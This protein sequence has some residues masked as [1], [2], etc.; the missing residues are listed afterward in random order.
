MLFKKQSINRFMSTAQ[1]LDIVVQ[2]RTGY[3]EQGIMVHDSRKLAIHYLRSSSF[4]IDMASLLPVDWLLLPQQMSGGDPI[5]AR[6]RP[7]CRFFRL[8][9][10]YRV[11]AFYYVYIFNSF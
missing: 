2:F 1:I 11:Y 7:A 8:V 6:W 5:L 4:L 3:L 10:L 9:K